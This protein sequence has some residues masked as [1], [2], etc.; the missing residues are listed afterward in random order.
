M[1][2]IRRSFPDKTREGL[3]LD[4]FSTPTKNEDG[5]PREI[6]DFLP[7][8][9]VKKLFAMGDLNSSDQPKM[10][11]FTKEKAAREG[12]KGCKGVRRQ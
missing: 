12:R 2:R 4:V 10:T 3:C 7:R 5:S 11:E 9:R 8:A 6:D 1:E